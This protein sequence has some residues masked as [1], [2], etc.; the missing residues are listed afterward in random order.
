MD[1]GTTLS[2]SSTKE[3]GNGALNMKILLDSLNVIR[4]SL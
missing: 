4:Q 3:I 2:L 1:V